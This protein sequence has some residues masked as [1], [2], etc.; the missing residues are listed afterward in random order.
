VQYKGAPLD[1]ERGPGLGCFRLQLVLLVIAIVL[2]PLS[3]AWSWPS[4]VSAA[5]LFLVIVLLFVSGQTIIFLLRLVAAE[6]RATGRRR[7]MA[8]QTRTVGELEDERGASLGEAD[9]HG[10]STGASGP[11][12]QGRVRQ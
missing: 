9:E 8:S 4:A 10:G 5:L 2:T 1:A 12:E 6:R 3:V 11:D 7:P